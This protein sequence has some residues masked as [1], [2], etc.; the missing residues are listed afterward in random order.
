MWRSLAIIVKHGP[1]EG[2]I[3]FAAGIIADI[4]VLDT[5]RV[6]KTTVHC[7]EVPRAH[8]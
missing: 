3:G 7:Q 6:F 1:V 4:Q 5:T 8:L 2:A